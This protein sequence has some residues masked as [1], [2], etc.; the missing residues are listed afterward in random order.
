MRREFMITSLV[1]SVS[2]A[3]CGGSRANVPCIKD[4]NCDLVSGG[5][6]AAAPTGTHWCAYGDSSCPS[7]L[8]FS[9]VD[10]GDGVAGQCVAGP[11]AGM[12]DGGVIDGDTACRTRVAFAEGGVGQ[13]EIWIANPDGSGFVNLSNNATADDADPSWAPNG[14]RVAFASNRTGHWDIFV[15]NVDGTGLTNLTDGPDVIADA[16]TPVWSPDGTRIA[17]IYGGQG[18]QVWVM[19]GNGTGAARVSNRYQV[20][21]LAWSSS[22]S[23]IVFGSISPAGVPELY[24]ITVGDGSPEVKLTSS[25]AFEGRA[26]W[27]PF[28]KIMFDDGAD[29]FTVNGNGTGLANITQN[30]TAVNT[31]GRLTTSGTTLVFTSERDGALNELWS[32]PAG[33]GTAT[34]LTRHMIA[35][36]G[37][38]L[39]DISVDSKLLA[40]RRRTTTVNGS[41]ETTVNAVGVVG[42]DGTG[43]HLFNAPS[44]SFAGNARFSACP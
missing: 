31:G 44:G 27:S 8:R 29:I 21:D 4:S 36:G 9:T 39:T 13:R 28:A 5:I 2:A 1:A 33:G 6:C 43:I 30:A 15:V 25:T 19:N 20:N 7:G 18:G 3:G 26:T 10:I 23:Q 42:I 34:Q 16:I 11:D 24:V 22:N 12:V 32:M 41:N 14:L 40:F 17:F 35:N 38:F 37:D